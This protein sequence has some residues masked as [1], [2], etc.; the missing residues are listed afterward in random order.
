MKIEAYL[1]SKTALVDRALDK[2]I[3][4]T[5]AWPLVLSQSVRYSLFS[6][7]KRIRPVLAI[8][9]AE[10]CGKQNQDVLRVACA[11]ECFHTYSLIH[12][13]LPAM[14]N[15]DFRRGRPSNHKKF[16]E[17]NALLA[18]DTL[19]TFG[20][21]LLAGVSQ[22]HIAAR[23]VQEIARGIG[24]KGMIG[25]QVEDLRASRSKKRVPLREIERIAKTKTACLIRVSCWAG[26]LA[27]GATDQEAKAMAKYG[28][29]L[30]LAFQ[31]VDDIMDGNGYLLY[32]SEKEA[33]IK[34]TRLTNSAHQ[35]VSIFGS[36]AIH[37]KELA[38]F[39]LHRKH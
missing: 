34:A 29:C 10:A 18:G 37:L 33:R 23:L 2:W 26:A 14:D 1:K 6:G 39:I 38:D 32:M 4:A 28:E 24:Q 20:F 31:M 27:G 15:D 35:A 22:P 16:G 8:A 36:K 30:G 17:A 3:P 7:G 9:S 13:D 5:T 25:G 11:L 19:L 12:D 21:E